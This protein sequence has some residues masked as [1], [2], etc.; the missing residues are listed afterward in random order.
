MVSVQPPP[1]RLARAGALP[2]GPRPPAWPPGQTGFPLDRPMPADRLRGWLL[3]ILLTIIGGIL[4]FYRL[5]HPTDGGTPVFDEKHYVPQAWQMLRNGGVE[6]NP[7]YELVVHPPLAKQLIALG[8][9]WQ[10]YDS[11]GWRVSAALAGTLCVLLLVR[12]ARRMTRS[13]LLGVLAGALLLCD[14]TSFV[15]SRMGMLDIFLTLFVLASFGAMVLDRDDVRARMAI[16]VAQ[17]RVHDSPFG[18]RMGVRWWR[19]AAGVLIGMACAVKWS[20]VY[21]VAAFGVLSLVWDLTARR[22]AGVARPWSGVLVRDVG[23][24]LWALAAVPVLTYFAGWWAWFA[25]ETGTDRYEVGQDIGPG[26]HFSFVPA[27]LRSLWYYSAHVLSFHEDLTTSKTNPHPWESKPW[28]WPMSLRPMLYYLNTNDRSC[29]ANDCVSSTMLIGTPALWWTSPAVVVWALWRVA[30][31][32]DWRYA[33]VLVGYGAG[34]LP[35]FLDIDRQM[36]FFYATPMAPFLVLGIT[37]ASGDVLG[38]ALAGAERRATGL[39]LVSL[40]LGLAVANFAWLWPIMV[41]DSIT[42]A[43]WNA[44]MWL[45]S[46]R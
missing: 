16:V 12:I 36:Y 43:H 23:P 28:T 6:D 21:W 4:R 24:A 25:S 14:G 29:G 32:F 26:G 10:G 13:T 19:F 31:R 9:W 39:L 41:G 34:Y 8:E 5:G 22:A 44:E 20:G 37:L 30:A 18:P 42:A 3:A 38:R 35:W 1:T 33:A 17:G 46:W 11:I 2:V 27:A 45:P 7:G 40:Y 15:Q